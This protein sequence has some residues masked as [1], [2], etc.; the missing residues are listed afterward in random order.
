MLNFKD[1]NEKNTLINY[2]T[3]INHSSLPFS[4]IKDN[5]EKELLILELSN[6]IQ[7]NKLLI[8]A[9]LDKLEDN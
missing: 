6:P 4:Y 5:A 8:E 3:K 2:Y 9:H 1:E 7:Y